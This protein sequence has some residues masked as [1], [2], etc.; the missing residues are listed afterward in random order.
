MRNDRLPV[1]EP[2]EATMSSGP[3]SRPAEDH[4]GLATV[5]VM[6]HRARS[7]CCC[8]QKNKQA[9]PM[10]EYAYLKRIRVLKA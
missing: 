10:W 4:S 5:N 1:T 7:C 6:I 8:D 3:R 9:V 2:V